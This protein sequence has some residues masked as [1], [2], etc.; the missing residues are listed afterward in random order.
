MSSYQFYPTYWSLKFFIEG[1]IFSIQADIIR[2]LQSRLDII[3]DEAEQD[4]NPS[5][6]GDNEDADDISKKPIS[7]LMLN[8]SMWVSC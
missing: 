1:G 8:S 4:L 5:D 6:V 3:C 2:S 7:K